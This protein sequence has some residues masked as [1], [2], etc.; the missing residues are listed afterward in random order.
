MVS[1]PNRPF[2][3]FL[4]V[5]VP[6][7]RY[8]SVLSE[9]LEV[10]HACGMRDV[11]EWGGRLGERGT[12]KHGIKWKIGTFG[13]SGDAIAELRQC[14][15]FNAWGEYLTIIGEGEHRVT[16]LD[17]AL[18]VVEDGAAAV[19]SMYRRAAR[20]QISLT[21]K[22]VPR[23]QCKRLT[24]PSL[25]GGADTG[26]VYLGRRTRDVYARVYDKRQELLQRA[27]DAHGGMTAE[28]LALNDPGP[29]TRYELVLGRHVGVSTR[30]AYEPAAVFWHFASESLLPKAALLEVPAAWR[31]HGPGFSMPRSAEPDYARQ[32]S[33]LL[34]TSRDVRRAVTLADR[35][36]PYGRDHLCRLI[37][38][39]SSPSLVPSL[40]N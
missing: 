37:K 22:P 39:A 16:R 35:L 5:T 2:A 19:H 26:T 21:R 33:L 7:D 14:P 6:E 3:D 28:L 32:L 25:Y 27:C 24:S 20:G 36:G 9:L 4:N 15:A 18:D 23:S 30:D 12:F 40:Q 38:A 17:V 11:E 34:E 10:L 29:L 31:P 8:E 13:L 1:L